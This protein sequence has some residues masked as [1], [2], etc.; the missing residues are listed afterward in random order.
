MMNDSTRVDRRPQPRTARAAAAI[1]ATAGLALPAA[2]FSS[3]GPSATVAGG[4]S[5]A[6]ASALSQSTNTQQALAFAR[7]MRSHGVR[8]WPDPNSSGIFPKLTAQQLDVSS[9]LL[10]A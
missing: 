1:I 6:R 9:S 4:S 2:A 7:C 8:N 5:T 10:Q 3:G